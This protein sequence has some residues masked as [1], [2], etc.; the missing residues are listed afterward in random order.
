MK[1]QSASYT[2]SHDTEYRKEAERTL[3]NSFLEMYSKKHSISSAM[4]SLF[5]FTTA[6]ATKILSTVSRV[7]LINLAPKC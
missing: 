1:W 3:S 4:G 7:R 2:T 5:Y 6:N